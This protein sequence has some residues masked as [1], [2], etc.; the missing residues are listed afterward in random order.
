MPATDFCNKIG[1]TRPSGIPRSRSAK[2]PKAARTSPRRHGRVVPEPEINCRSRAPSTTSAR[3]NPV[4][5]GPIGAG[6]SIRQGLQLVRAR[7]AYRAR[8]ATVWSASRRRASMLPPACRCTSPPLR[9]RCRRPSAGM[10]RTRNETTSWILCGASR[11][12][13]SRIFATWHRISNTWSSGSSASWSWTPAVS[14][15]VLSD[16]ATFLSLSVH[17]SC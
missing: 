9:W 1:T 5:A 13:G 17:P 10:P 16:Q 11:M 6:G 15:T 2:R 14:D 7:E 4:D 3:R 8:P 12:S